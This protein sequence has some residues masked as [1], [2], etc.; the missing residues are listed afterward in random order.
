MQAFE[1]V[2]TDAALVF[3]STFLDFS[4]H[5][6][7]GT[8]QVNHQVG[9][10]HQGYHQV[11][12]VAVVVIIAAAHKPHIVQV[13][14]K[15]VGIFVYRAVLYN[16]IVAPADLNYVAEALVQEIDLQVERPS[17]HILVKICEI[18]VVVNWFKAGSPFEVLAE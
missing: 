12:Q 5:V 2:D 6:G 15:D 8:A 14:G 18:G 10:I 13:G 17:L 4:H 3:A 9:S 16:Y 1:I 11:K 7:D